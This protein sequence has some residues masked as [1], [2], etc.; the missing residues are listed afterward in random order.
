MVRNLALASFALGFLIFASTAFAQGQNIAFPIAEL[1]GCSSKEQCKTYCDDPANIESC[2]AFAE[3]NGLM[4]RDEAAQARTFAGKTGPGGCRGPECRTLCAD[5]AY[6]AECIAFAREHGLAPPQGP[7]VDEPTIDEDRAMLVVEERG[8]PGGCR[9]KDECRAF[10]DAEG[11]ME[12][13]LAFAAE[14]DLM[15]PQDLERARKMMTA[16]GLGGCRGMACR[17]YC[18]N[19]EHAEACLA[20]AEEQGFMP[21]EEAEKARRLMNATGPGGC[22][23]IECKR[24]CED[25]AHQKECFEF[26]I[27]NGLISEEEAARARAFMQGKG[28]DEFGGPPEGF[29]EF[30]GPG[31]CRGPEECTRYCNEH[32]EECRGFGPPPAEGRDFGQDR[33]M[34]MR[35][36]EVPSGMQCKT[37]EECRALYEERAREFRHEDAPQGGPFPPK[38]EFPDD[39]GREFNAEYERQY[40]QQYQ[41][42]YEGMGGES[43]EFRPP[44]GYQPPPGDGYQQPP[45]NYEPAPGSLEPPPSEPT[46]RI[47]ASNFVAAVFS[48]VAQLLGL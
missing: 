39:Y 7:Q 31:R 42:L 27:E 6:R 4:S 10:C 8:G 24:R 12:M 34:D 29:E 35:G 46:S 30:A 36:F 28:S 2:V 37:P 48:I 13:C 25:P 15:S 23:G 32:P 20:F 44:E 3:A 18:E 40:Q 19:P 43:Q 16:G 38:R 45:Q 33:A 47:P 11:N 1:G 41:Q 26:A 14:H 22:R 17:A 21:K 5:P 9:T